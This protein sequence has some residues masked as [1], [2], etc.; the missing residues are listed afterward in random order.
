MRLELILPALPCRLRGADSR[1]AAESAGVR[2]RKPHGSVLGAL[3]QFKKHDLSDVWLIE[4]LM[5]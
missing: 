2:R 1:E 3:R 5:K 4:P